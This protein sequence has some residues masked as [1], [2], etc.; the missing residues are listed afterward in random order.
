[1]GNGRLVI[2]LALLPALFL[3]CSSSGTTGTTATDTPAAL[4]TGLADSFCAAQAACCGTTGTTT[5]GGTVSCVSD[6]GVATGLASTCQERAALAADQQLA[7]IS[8]AFSEGLLTIDPDVSAKCAAAYRTSLTCAALAAEPAINVQTAL[9]DPT[10]LNLFTGYIP[11]GERCDM[12]AECVSGSFCLSQ[13][14]GQPATAIA[15]SGTLGV[16]FAYVQM[17]GACNTS[18][19]CAPLLTCNP[20]TLVCG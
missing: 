20:S 13:G 4:A 18:D 8:T 12:S 16:C 15:G 17:G 10:C 7:L 19:D 1:M 6:A 5:D 2:C 3:A 14:T 9:D 11:V